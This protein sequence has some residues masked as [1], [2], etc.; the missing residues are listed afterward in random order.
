[1]IGAPDPSHTH[2]PPNQVNLYI[3]S[4]QITFVH[5]FNFDRVGEIGRGKMVEALEY[6]AKKLSSYSWEVLLH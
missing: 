4:K 3:F 1:M 5:C 6:L 2:S